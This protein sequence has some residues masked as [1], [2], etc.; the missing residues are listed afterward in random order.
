MANKDK[1]E[2]F[3]FIILIKKTDLKKDIKYNSVSKLDQ[4]TYGNDCKTGRGF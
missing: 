2:N 1:Y 4:L 3:L